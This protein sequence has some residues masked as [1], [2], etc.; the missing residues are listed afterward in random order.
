MRSLNDDDLN[1]LLREAKARPPMPSPDLAT[2]VTGAYEMQIRSSSP[3]RRLFFGTVRMRI[4]V[5][6]VA[7]FVLLF[8]G[9]VLGRRAPQA[10]TAGVEAM[11]RDRPVLNLDGLQPVTD[12]RLRIVRRAHE[13]Q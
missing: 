9:V 10:Q 13:D 4:P 5:L 11:E 3:W 2:R 6:V 7:S 8:V 1:A 12:L